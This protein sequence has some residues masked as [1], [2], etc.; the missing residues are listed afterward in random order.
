MQ[1]ARGF[2]EAFNG[3]QPLA[4]DHREENKTGIDR[5]VFHFSGGIGFRYHHRARAAIAFRA[6]FF[7]TFMIG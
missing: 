6:A 3:D 5:N 1:A 2:T 4:V 7:R